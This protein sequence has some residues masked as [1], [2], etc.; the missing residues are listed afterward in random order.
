MSEQ[1]ETR[2]LKLPISGVDVELYTYILGG[3]KRALA[4]IE[5]M[6]KAQEVMIEKIV[7]KIGEQSQN[8][9]GE[10]DKLHGK[11]FDFLLA[12]ITKVIND[13]SWT[14]KKTE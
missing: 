7:V 14:E 5:D 12:E 9:V 2:S 13:S 1:R 6:A 8:P 10:A 4:G 3:D 11:D